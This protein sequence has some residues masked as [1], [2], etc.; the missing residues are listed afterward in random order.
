MRVLVVGG[1]GLV[2]TRLVE[3][4]ARD[5]HQAVVLSRHPERVKG[6]PAGARAAGW[7]GRSLGSW[8]DE[9]AAADGVVHLAG[10]SIF[11][12]WT[13]KRKQAIRRSRV[14]SSRLVA[15]AIAAAPRRP[16]V[17]VQGSAIGIYGDRGDAPVD[18]S[19]PVG[20]DFL[21]DVGREWE[22]A[23][24]GVEALGVRRPLARTGIVLSR[25]GGALPL[26]RLGFLTFCGGPLGSG[27]QWF[28]WIHED[29]EV[30]ALRFLLDTPAAAGPYNLVAPEPVTNRDFSRA[31]GDALRR[32]SWLPVPRFAL[33]LAVGELGDV[34]L[35]GQRATPARLLAAGFTFRFP[36]VHEALAELLR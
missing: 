12:R 16:Q 25:R 27:R 24:A 28:P 17:L 22:E 32:P 18:E 8:V 4:L 14:D 3:S 2:G 35:G 31:I 23:S 29:D 34:L 11:G 6:L 36:R 7:S 15:E 20:D 26:M 10:A 1:S 13:G 21:A 5:G 9:V 30:A 19:S 33:R